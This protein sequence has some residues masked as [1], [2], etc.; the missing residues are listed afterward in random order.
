MT[1]L[2]GGHVV[3]LNGSP[4]R[5]LVCGGRTFEDAGLIYSTLDEV[6]KYKI[7]WVISG[8]AK[9]ADFWAEEWARS[10]EVPFLV[11]PA[12]WSVHGNSAGPIRNQKMLDDCRPTIV[13]AFPGGSGTAHMVSVAQKFLVPVLKISC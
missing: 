6:N 2:I 10:R 1:L 13:I 5:V 12:Q 3:L 8:G 11:V 7:G 9:G 4:E